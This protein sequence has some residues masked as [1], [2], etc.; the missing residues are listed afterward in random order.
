[1][2]IAGCPMLDLLLELGAKIKHKGLES[3]QTGQKKNKLK[4]LGTWGVCQGSSCSAAPWSGCGIWRVDRW[5][6]T[7]LSNY[8]PHTWWNLD[9]SWHVFQTCYMVYGIW[10]MHC[11]FSI[12][13]PFFSETIT[14]LGGLENYIK[15]ASAFSL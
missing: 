7:G 6:Y 10:Y 13:L 1:M 2:V 14:F 8:G 12:I 4:V 9:N 3:L 5:E 11:F 15:C